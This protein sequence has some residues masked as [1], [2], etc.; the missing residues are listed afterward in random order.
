MTEASQR[1][2]VLRALMLSA[3]RELVA[4]LR[5]TLFAVGGVE[6]LGSVGSARELGIWRQRQ[7]PD[8]LF[9]DADR[10]EA[11]ADAVT[12]AWRKERDG[13]VLVALTAHPE[14]VPADMR[15]L[16]RPPG[17]DA[18]RELVAGLRSSAGKE[19]GRGMPGESGEHGPYT[20]RLLVR[21]PGHVRLLPVEEILWIDAVHNAVKIHSPEGTFRLRQTIAALLAQLDPRMF[22]RIHRS[23][24]VQLSTAKEF[25]VNRRGQYS[26]VMPGG[27]K[28]AVSRSYH[29]HLMARLRSEIDP[30]SK[31]V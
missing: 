16:L 26:V 18:A 29:D 30:L 27:V 24:I 10:L 6:L 1:D 20:R 13:T 21:S 14:H 19:L 12:A 23:T 22:V 28:L 8:L 2:V 9:V 15:T 4:R 5:E 11:E 17:A 7:Q 25:R 31:R 3:D